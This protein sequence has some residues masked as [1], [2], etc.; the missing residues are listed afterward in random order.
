MEILISM[1]P[2]TFLVASPIIVA[3]LG[4]MISE[5]CGIVNI[6][7][8]GIMLFGAFA[9]ATSC[10]FL[11]TTQVFGPYAGW[12]S[13]LIGLCAGLIFSLFL[14]VSTINF[15]ADHTIAGTAI[16]LLSVGISVYLCQIIF[17]QQRSMAFMSGISKMKSVPILSDIPIIGDFLSS[18]YP[19]IIIALIFVFICYFTIFKTGFGLRLRSCGENPQAAASMGINVCKM[20]YFGVL[21]SGA[22]GGLAGA[23]MVLTNGVQFTATSIHGVGFIAIAAVIFGKWNPFGI[24]GAGLFFG[25]SSAIGIYAGNIPLLK[26]LPSEFFACIPYVLTIVALVVF[27]NK[28]V[29][30]KAAGQIYDV[31]KR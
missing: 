11:E 23:M 7:I 12:I 3:A 31:G 1:I 26:L 21:I 16:N 14:A 20:R 15:N 25:L 17:G 18:I 2:A 30:P 13:L 9:A 5:R 22:L 4:G 27:S 19:T 29:G 6:A 10:Y 8:E 24:L 28:T